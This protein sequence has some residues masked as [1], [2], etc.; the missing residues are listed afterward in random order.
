MLEKLR[1]TLVDS[2]VGA[3]AL[4]Y[5]LAQG[6]LSFVGIFSSPAA[7]WLTRH[8]LRALTER[9]APSSSW[10][11]GYYAMPELIRSI[12]LLLV[13]YLLFRWLFFNPFETSA[14]TPAPTP[15]VPD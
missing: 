14:S 15:S 1:K 5:L 3:I 13:W 7:G 4:G 6:I 11:L 8:E 10:P 2:Y 12:V 9:I